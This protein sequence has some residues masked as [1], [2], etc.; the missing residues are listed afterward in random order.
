MIEQIKDN[1]EK[2]KQNIWDFNLALGMIYKEL[3]KRK[4][5]EDETGIKE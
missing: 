2:N 5:Q 4:V 1:I 3:E